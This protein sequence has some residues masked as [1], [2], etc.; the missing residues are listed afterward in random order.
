MGSQS[1]R[2][3]ERRI[4]Q[5]ADRGEQKPRP[6]RHSEDP[7]VRAAEAKLRRHLGSQ[8]RIVPNA[9]GSPG[10]I[11]IE[12][13]STQDLNRLYELIMSADRQQSNLASATAA[14]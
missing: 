1:V 10:R 4:R 9:P 14:L 5:L 7:N 8:V 3:T 13:Y 12:F 6:A 2:E 11:E